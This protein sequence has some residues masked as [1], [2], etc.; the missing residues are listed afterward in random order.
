VSD[1]DDFRFIGSMPSGVSFDRT[2]PSE[3]PDGIRIGRHWFS[4]EKLIVASIVGV[5][6]ILGIGWTIALTS[7]KTHVNPSC[8]DTGSFSLGE[9]ENK[10]FT[11]NDG[12]R[13]VFALK[14][15]DSSGGS[16]TLMVGEQVDSVQFSLYHGGSWHDFQVTMVDSKALGLRTTLIFMASDCTSPSGTK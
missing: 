2:E 5:A 4:A 13:A 14:S 8:R 9:N 16:G 1:D 15:A 6:L 10:V 12:S 7:N 3:Q 11:L